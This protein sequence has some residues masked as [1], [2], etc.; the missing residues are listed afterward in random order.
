MN[1]KILIS[2]LE[3]LRVIASKCD[4]VA[5]HLE[6]LLGERNCLYFI[7][8]RKNIDVDGFDFEEATYSDLLLKIK[9]HARHLKCGYEIS[10]TGKNMFI[11][12]YL[13]KVAEII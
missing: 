6:A 8:W 12:E 10:N 5:E 4:W 13:E 3:K 1:K 11:P 9:W 2:K 7:Y